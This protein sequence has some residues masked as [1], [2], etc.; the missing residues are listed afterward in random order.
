MKPDS[1]AYSAAHVDAASLDRLNTLY[2]GRESNKHEKFASFV[3][4][5]CLRKCA[6]SWAY[7]SSTNNHAEVI[8]VSTQLARMAS[9]INEIVHSEQQDAKSLT[10]RL[11][12]LDLRPQIVDFYSSFLT[13]H[14]KTVYRCLSS[15]KPSMAN[16]ILRLLTLLFE[17]KDAG[18]TAEFVST[19]DFQ[20][21]ILGKF[22]VPT[23]LEIDEHYNNDMTMRYNFVRFWIAVNSHVSSF[24]R[25][26][27]LLNF[28]IMNNLWKHLDMDSRQTLL[29]ILGFLDTKVLDDPNFKRSTKCRILNE[30]FMHKTQLLF[31]NTDEAVR[32]VFLDL[33]NKIVSD[34][35]NGLVYSA[36][37]EGTV[38]EVN[39]KAFKINN[40]LIYT[41]LTTLKPW[42]SFIQLLFA[43]S[44]MASD[45]ELIPPYLNWIIQSGGGGYHDPSLSSW[46]I[47]HTLLFTEILKI[48]LPHKLANKHEYVCLA[49][50]SKSA[51]VKCI[52]SPVR[53]IQQLSLQLVMFQLLKL[54][55]M[56]PDQNLKELV[57]ANLPSQASLLPLVNHENKLIKLTSLMILNQYESLVPSSS[58]STLLTTISS[59]INQ[60]NMDDCSTFEL[61]LLDNYLSIQSSND[62]KWWNRSKNDS[63]CFFTNLIKL[64]KYD[65]LKSKIAHILIRLTNDT[66]IFNKALIDSP[67]TALTQLVSGLLQNSSKVWKLLDETVS[68]AIKTPYKYL[69]L[70]HKSYLDV[71]L[72]VIVLFE[73]LNFVEVD[74]EIKTWLSS[75]LKK[76]VIIGEPENAIESLSQGLNLDLSF[77]KPTTQDVRVPV[78]KFE[79]AELNRRLRLSMD[80]KNQDYLVDVLTKIG[81]FLTTVEDRNL[82]RYATTEDF[83]GV[84]FANL[85]SAEISSNEVIVIGLLNEIFQQI[86]DAFERSEFSK[87]ISLAFKK[88][89]V[90][91]RTS[92]HLLGRF[93]WI[94]TN[95]ELTTLAHSAYNNEYLLLKVYEEVIERSFEIKPDFERLLQVEIPEFKAIMLQLN[96]PY[97][98]FETILGKPEAHFLLPKLLQNEKAVEFLS[99]KN[100]SDSSLL[101]FMGA[102]S[103]ALLRKNIE[104]I[105]PI[106]LGL[107]DWTKSL[108]IFSNGLKLFDQK[109]VLDKVFGYV[110]TKGF[111][112]SAIPQFAKFVHAFLLQSITDDER[113]NNWV[114]KAMLYITKKFAES[115]SLSSNF[116]AFLSE[117]EA[118]VRIL[119][120]RKSSIWKV[121][122]ISI[123]NA[124]IE[125]FL[126]HRQWILNTTYLKYINALITTG[127][128]NVIEFEKQLQIFVN[129][130]NCVLTKLPSKENSYARF[131]S[132]LVLH[133][134]FQLNPPKNA[135]VD[136]LGKLVLL[137]LGSNRAEDVVL[138]GILI[139]IE[140]AVSKTWISRVSSWDLQEELTSSEVDMIGE[141]RLII[142]DKNKLVVSLNKTFIRNTVKKV[143]QVAE[144]SGDLEAFYEKC[145]SGPYQ[146]TCYDPEFLML[147]IINNEE[148]VSEEEGKVKFDVKKLVEAGLLQ[149]IVYC[150]SIGTVHRIA[151][152][153]L[154]GV[155][156]SFDEADSFK[157]KNLFRV[158][159]SNILNSLRT[160]P[161]KNHSLVWYTYASLVPV[162]A[163]PGHFL[164]EKAYRYVLSH[165]TVKPYEVPLFREISTSVRN[166][167]GGTDEYYYREVIWLLEALINGTK[168]D[169]DLRILRYKSVIEWAMNLSNSMFASF[170][171]RQLV[172]Q[173]VHALQGISREGADVLVTKF[174]VLAGTQQM[175]D[176]LSENSLVDTQ[177]KAN[178]EAISLRFGVLVHGNKRLSEW[179]QGDVA[180]HVKRIRK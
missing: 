121:A 85:C 101:Y 48:E 102:I 74:D 70:S 124:Q 54:Q 5:G 67:I 87:F 49:P 117:I 77:P 29:L 57:L 179:T 158:Y 30:N 142:Q 180:N 92:Q 178:L 52:E 99:T 24:V 55:K 172:L 62:L 98:N 174:S 135:T 35:A 11:R 61:T 119:P 136:L 73:Q 59:Q 109:E 19:F 6:S 145:P 116:D 110:E 163:N 39:N 34:P 81:N 104:R 148:L 177:L 120:S 123:V 88:D 93:S 50:L 105:S 161:E 2:Q 8:K 134:L 125:A 107:K 40:K 173:L 152:I 16:P 12:F 25:K 168:T 23:K 103:P 10:Q 36:S 131:Q 65:M 75:F 1:Q 33:M 160:E 111:K 129:N 94:L 45:P 95:E 20:L 154:H 137:Y 60:I 153:L 18:L 72:F 14:L 108:E 146:E 127:L 122:P 38:V 176:G 28:K 141:E 63:N 78:T 156:K 91:S 133:N 17:Y 46:W 76:L 68:R 164:Y 100:I 64:S 9:S 37:D 114:H 31:N 3:D 47:G 56:D 140:K 53:L 157:D 171:I 96:I 82:V 69:D 151:R 97:E 113:V 13:D 22:L 4:L 126:K 138:K 86:S 130:Q 149:F 80:T 166:E 143:A 165:P 43:V 112:N 118:I 66:L 89:A 106:A 26:D 41:L 58:T 144:F 139:S 147:L 79:F 167:E 27:L 21:P 42:E 44:V 155:L 90:L 15:Y 7:Y 132:S 162:L 83:W 159:V 170:R 71:S 169:D 175:S 51:L 84:F 128:K 32:P 115:A 150:L